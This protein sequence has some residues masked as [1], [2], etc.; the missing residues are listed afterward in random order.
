MT[1]SRGLGRRRAGSSG[2]QATHQESAAT[3]VIE[4]H[5]GTTW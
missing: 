2:C 5:R 1:T 4:G 3:A